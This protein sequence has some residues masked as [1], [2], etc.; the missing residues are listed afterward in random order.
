[1]ETT[2]TRDVRLLGGTSRV[3]RALC[4]RSSLCGS[5]RFGEENWRQLLIFREGL[6]GPKR[7]F[8]GEVASVAV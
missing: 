6:L 1:M 7:I 4:R 2:W 5:L 3:P 8:D